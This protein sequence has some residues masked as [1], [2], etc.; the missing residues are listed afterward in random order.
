MIGVLLAVSIAGIILVTILLVLNLTVAVGTINGL[1]FYAN[2]V[3]STSEP[4]TFALPQIVVAW[5]NLESGFDGC[6]INGL[7]AYWR[8]WLRFVFPTYVFFLVASVIALSRFSPKFSRIIGKRNPVTTLNTLILLSYSKLLNL[9]ISIFL[10]TTLDCPGGSSKSVKVWIVDATIEYLSPKHFTL[11]IVAILILFSGTIYTFL[12]FSWQ[13]LLLYQDKWLFRWVRNQKLCQF[14]EPYHAPYTFKHRYWTGLL[15]LVRVILF[16]ILATNT[17]QDPYLSLVAISIAVSS[18]FLLKGI[19]SRIYRNHLPNI[20]ETFCLIKFNILFLCIS[21]FYTIIKGY[22]KMQKDLAYVSG[23]AITLLFIFI[24]AY[25][26]Y[27]EIIIKSKIWI[28]LNN[29]ILK[30][31]AMIRDV[32]TIHRTVTSAQPLSYTTSVVEAP[33]REEQMRLDCAEPNLRELLL[34]SSADGTLNFL[35]YRLS[36]EFGLIHT[37]P[38]RVGYY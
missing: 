17:S 22:S 31:K 7:N 33:K 5:L 24:T 30:S 28:V 2:I 34:E 20:L 32:S 4:L 15:L 37:E 1:I 36:Y 16:T 8:T 6:F 21:N 29:L 38:L 13:W 18:L 25:H 14:L 10:F 19:F 35:Y 26:V 3:H 23:S 27:T 12:L 11:F 9:V